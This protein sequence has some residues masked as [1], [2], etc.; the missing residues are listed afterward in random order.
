MKTIVYAISKNESAFAERWMAS[1]SEADGVYV[2]D[3]GSDDGTAEKLAALGAV[4]KTE[5]IT[6]WRFDAARNRSLFLVES[7]VVI[8][9]LTDFL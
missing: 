7:V 9:F 3:T 8:L 5:R 1:M 6:P 4:V 2:L